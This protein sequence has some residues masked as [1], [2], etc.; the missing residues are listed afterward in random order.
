MRFIIIHVYNCYIQLKG[1]W[2]VNRW[3]V[4]PTQNVSDELYDYV[5]EFS[6]RPGQPDTYQDDLFFR[7]D[8]NNLNIFKS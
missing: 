1:R 3:Y 8:T 6:E 7:S 4:P 5:Q 2:Y